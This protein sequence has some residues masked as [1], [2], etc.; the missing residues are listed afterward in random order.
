MDDGF[1]FD[2]TAFGVLAG[3]PLV[4]LAVAYDGTNSGVASGA[5]FIIDNTGTTSFL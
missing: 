2:E 5:A 3:V 1:V 4:P